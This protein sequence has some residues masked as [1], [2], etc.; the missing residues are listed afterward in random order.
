[1][2]KLAKQYSILAALS[3]AFVSWG[4][5]AQA[6]DVVLAKG[7]FV[8]KSG[9]KVSGKVSIVKTSTGVEVRLARGFLLDSAPGPY[10]GFGNNGKYVK[11]SQ[12]SK[13][14]KNTGAQTY[15]LPAGIDVSKFN[16]FYVWCKPFN[17]PLGLAK[18]SK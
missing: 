1:M 8:G 2:N 7:S 11:A 17:V 4:V 3:V 10:L 15:K 13:L 12:F 6:A 18:L 14:Q 9:H 5:S 16:E